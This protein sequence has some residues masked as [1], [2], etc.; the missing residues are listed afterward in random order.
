MGQS[1]PPGRETH[2]REGAN[3][4]PPIYREMMPCGCGCGCGCGW[5]RGDYVQQEMLMSQLQAKTGE[6]EQEQN[7]QK[8]HA[9][10]V[11]DC[12]VARC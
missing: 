5:D 1:F 3:E 9:L 2:G 10:L 4:R 6:L 12:H 7:R 8:R 11:E